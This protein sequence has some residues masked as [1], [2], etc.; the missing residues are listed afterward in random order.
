MAADAEQRCYV[1]LEVSSSEHPT[2]VPCSTCSERHAHIRCMGARYRQSYQ[3]KCSNCH[4][5]FS[6]AT[7]TSIQAA[8]AEVIAEDDEANWLGHAAGPGWVD[9]FEEAPAEAPSAESAEA[10]AAVIAQHPHVVFAWENGGPRSRRERPSCAHCA[11][12]LCPLHRNA[13][14]VRFC[15]VA[16]LLPCLPAALCVRR[17]K[18]GHWQ[19]PSRDHEPGALAHL[20]GQTHLRSQAPGQGPSQECVPSPHLQIIY[21]VCKM[22]MQACTQH[23]TNC[24]LCSSDMATSVGVPATPAA[25]ASRQRPCRNIFLRAS[26]LQRWPGTVKAVIAEASWKLP[27]AH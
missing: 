13:C 1:C 19:L 8:A 10:P 26:L 22:Y 16:C 3:A 12:V 20:R 6:P 21:T 24:L 9:L 15:T 5:A 25:A 18:G 11:V 2:V 27:E 7:M 23:L 17:R 4:T 14:E